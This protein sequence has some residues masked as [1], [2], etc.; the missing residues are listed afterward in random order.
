[1]KSIGQVLIDM[2]WD[3]RLDDLAARLQRL[4]PDWGD[5]RKFYEQRDDIVDQMRRIAKEAENG[6]TQQRP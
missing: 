3:Q 1:M 2:G 4:G 6:S 5:Q